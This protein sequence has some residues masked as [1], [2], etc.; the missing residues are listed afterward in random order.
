MSTVQA[1][2][3]HSVVV[4]VVVAAEHVFL[5]VR[6]LLTHI[7]GEKRKRERERMSLSFFLCFTPKLAAAKTHFYILPK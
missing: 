2:E 4:V 1:H 6:E 3:V 7:H 5:V